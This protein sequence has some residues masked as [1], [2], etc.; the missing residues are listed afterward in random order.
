MSTYAVGLC[1]DVTRSRLALGLAQGPR[2]L[3]CC[4]LFVGLGLLDL[5]LESC[6]NGSRH[7]LFS[8]PVGGI[9][10]EF[11]MTPASRISPP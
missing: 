3:S 11:F 4:V 1:T 5:C 2:K 8:S 9:T 6:L 7:L 10:L